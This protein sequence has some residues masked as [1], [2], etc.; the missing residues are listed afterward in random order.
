MFSILQI[1]C[2]YHD[3]KHK[4]FSSLHMSSEYRDAKDKMFSSVHISSRYRDA[5]GN[6]VMTRQRGDKNFVKCCVD[7]SP[8][9]KIAV[10]KNKN[11]AVLNYF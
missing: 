3:A 8:D 4:I 5:M 2:Q 11:I 6:I 7:C 10:Y 1:G 9:C